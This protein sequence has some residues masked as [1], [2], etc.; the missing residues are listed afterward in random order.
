ME[1]PTKEQLKEWD[2][3]L[4]QQ[5]LSMRRGEN[6]HLVY[7]D[8]LDKIEHLSVRKKLYGGKRVRPKGHGP[9]ET[10]D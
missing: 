4:A 3:I 1:K 2:R 6:E 7:S 5:G 9:D 8:D 10:V